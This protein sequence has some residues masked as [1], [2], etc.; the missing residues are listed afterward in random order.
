MRPQIVGFQGEAGSYSE[1]A[2][3]AHFGKTAS[4]RPFRTVAEVFEA[5]SG[6]VVEAG[7][8]P[9]E[10]S[11][12]G[13]VYESYD[14]L[15][16]S[17]LHVVAEVYLQI[18][19]CLIANHGVPI[20]RVRRVYSHPQ[21]IEQCRKHLSKLGVE[22]LSTYDTAGSVRAIKES[23]STDSAAIA[24]LR[25]AEIHGLGILERNIEDNPNNTT[26]FLV[27]SREPSECSER[28]KTSIVFQ[29]PNTAG[30]LHGALGIFAGRSINLSKIESRPT[31]DKPWEYFFLL[32]FIGGM[33]EDRCVAAMEELR[34]VASFVRVLGSY[35]QGMHP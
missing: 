5:V 13:N 18:H 2:I 28:C 3:T 16:S 24:S 31:R 14:M 20:H 9:V 30:S 35:Q 4:S 29:I 34:G 33:E 25:A 19:H 8:I 10:N 22:M 23:G 15:I 21:A 27:V 7:M 1:E 26:R 11:I 17:P 12:G 6:K 32:D